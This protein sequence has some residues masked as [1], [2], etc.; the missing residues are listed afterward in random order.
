MKKLKVL[1]L[2]T[3]ISISS[4][5]QE[6]FGGIYFDSTVPANQLHSLKGDLSYLY[7]LKMDNTDN[8]FS[9]Y[10]ELEEVSGPFLY[11]WIYNRVKYIVGQDYNVRGRNYVTKR[12]HTF[13]ATPLPGSS[14]F[15][16]TD[17]FGGVVVMSNIGAGLYLSGKKSKLLKGTKINRNKVFAT[18]PRVGILQI[19]EGLFLDSILVNKETDSEANKIKRLGTLFHEARHSDGNSEHIG[20]N[21]HTCPEGHTLYGFSAC[22]KYGNG[23]YQLEAIATKNLLLNCSTCSVEDKTKLEASIAD[24]F[25]RV[26]TISHRKS[27]EQLLH[28]MESYK[29]VIDFYID[30]MVMSPSQNET[31]QKELDRFTAMYDKAKGQLDELINR[32]APKMMN[33][34][35]EGEFHELSVEESSKLIEASIK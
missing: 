12:G 9:S 25:D 6:K 31:S 5:A 33:S 7:Q 18:S 2:M 34:T 3:I 22:E 4:L 29:K 20:F 21:H 14:S 24:A 1:S 26:L 11:N 8:D 13:P 17:A 30:F 15:N 27:K 10:F 32:P 19:G 28:E 35:P 23:S 16:N